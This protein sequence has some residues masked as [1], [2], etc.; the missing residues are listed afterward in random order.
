[1]KSSD[2]SEQN[3]ITFEAGRG[4]LTTV[5]GPVGCGK[6]TLL[7]TILGEIKP[8]SGTI[9]VRSPYIAYCSQSAWI[10]NAKIRDA[11][12]GENEYDDAWYHKII[13]ICELDSDF[14]QMP[15]SDQSAVGSRGIVLSGGQ[16]HRVVG[17]LVLSDPLIESTTNE[18]FTLESCKSTIFSLL[19]VAARRLP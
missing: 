7:R 1:M 14:S 5:L 3:A 16:K 2:K 13:G 9:S 15:N 11:I 4:T 10:P 12:I 18:E 8:A 17:D 19:C 6:S